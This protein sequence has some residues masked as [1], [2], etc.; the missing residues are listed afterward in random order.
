MDN[1]VLQ[2]AV[3]EFVV[4][5]GIRATHWIDRLDYTEEVRDEMNFPIGKA[6]RIIFEY[7]DTNV[8]K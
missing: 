7:V 1:L 6:V 8:D 5:G 3:R 2:A 4:S